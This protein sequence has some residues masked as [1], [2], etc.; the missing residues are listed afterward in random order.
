MTISTEPVA[1]LFAIDDAVRLKMKIYI[2]QAGIRH[3][4]ERVLRN[5]GV[6]ERGI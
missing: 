2:G 1:V 5:S 3:S 4:D 6:R